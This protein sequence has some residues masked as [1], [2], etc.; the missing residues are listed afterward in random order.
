MT[1]EK[2]KDN[3]FNDFEITV[4]EKYP[5]LKEIKEDLYAQGATYASMSG[6][7]SAMFG[8]FKK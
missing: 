7:G 6:S 4:F 5:K 8:L 1:V 2:W 3:L